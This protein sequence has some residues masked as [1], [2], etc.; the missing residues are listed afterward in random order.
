VVQATPPPKAPVE[1]TYWQAPIWRYGKDNK[2]PNAPVDEWIND[3]IDRFMKANPD[4]KVKLELIPWDQWGAKVNTAL[5]A[6][7]PPDL[8]YGWPSI[9][10]VQA[11]VIEPVDD[12]LTPEIKAAWSPVMLKAIT[13]YGKVYGIP[14]IA[15]PNMYALSKTALKKYGGAEFIPTDEMRY[16]TIQNLEKLAAAYSDGKTR[17]AIGIPVGDHPA[18]IY[19][20]LAQQ[21]LGRGVAVW[22]DTQE[23]FIAHENPRSVEALQWFVD[24]QKKGYLIP[25]LPK[26]S[27]VDTFYWTL[28][29]AARGQW[30][31]IQ[32]EL[33]TAQAAGQ[34]Q[35]EFEI[36]LCSHPYDEK[37]KPHLAGANGGGALTLGKSTNPDKRAAAFRLGNWYAMD[38][39]NGVAWVVNGFFP[40][41][42]PQI[43]AAKGHPALSDPNK[44]WTLDIYMQ[45]YESEPNS[46]YWIPNSNPRTG[47]IMSD[48][49]LAD[50]SASSY[51]IRQFQSLLLGKVTPADMIKDL[52]IKINTALGA[53]V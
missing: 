16:F 4:I 19:F 5:A 30:A 36:V 14:T 39:S 41:T 29:C 20:D 53:K 40:S 18:A 27:D 23:R 38:P 49:K 48:E 11:G 10:Y 28:N 9:Q 1:I 8:L 45:K 15:N 17:Y 51:L 37:L 43:E 46:S 7:T 31:G 6:G 13:I 24:M 3:S 44:R 42:K 34:A 21:F 47:K 2:T 32:T 25:N 35:K 52:A 26:W 50:Y 33:E 22:D 12:Y